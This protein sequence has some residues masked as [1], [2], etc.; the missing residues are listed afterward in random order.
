MA[1]KTHGWKGKVPFVIDRPVPA[2]WKPEDE[3]YPKDG[4]FKGGQIGYAETPWGNKDLSQPNHHGVYWRDNFE[5]E[6]VLVFDRC[7]R[8]RSAA[9]FHFTRESDGTKVEFMMKELTRCFP[10]FKDGKIYGRFTFVKRGA[11][12]SC[13]VIDPT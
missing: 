6:D 12:F 8:G 1:K 11:N 2:H 5:F 3:W 7:E 13:S 4:V 9:T 10:Y